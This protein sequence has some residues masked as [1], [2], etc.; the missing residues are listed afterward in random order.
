MKRFLLG[1]AL[2]VPSAGAAQ[3][4]VTSTPDA[5]AI[6]LADAVRQAQ[7]NAPTT[8]QARGA[9]RT[10][11]AA[12]RSALG[13][14]LPTVN[15]T[16]GASSSV[17]TTLNTFTGNLQRLQDT[18]AWSSNQG[19]TATLPLFTGFQRW[20]AVRSTNADLEAA[21]ANE[22]AARYSVALVVK[23]QYF[24]ALAAREQLSAARAQLEASEQQFRAAVARVSAGAATKS[25]SLRSVITLGNAQ[26]AMLT[27][28]NN[29]LVA[30]AA[31][32]RLVQSKT[33]VTPVAADTADPAPIALDSTALLALAE[34]GPTVRTARAQLAS[35]QASKAG[36]LSSYLPTVSLA[37]ST[38]GSNALQTGPSVTRPVGW[39]QRFS[40]NFTYPIFNGFT[41]EQGVVAASVAEENASAQL[42]D[43]LFAA[44]QNLAQLLG[45]L[46]TAQQQITI[47]HASVAAADEDLRVQTQRYSLG[48]STL[49]D[50]LT[51]Q[52]ALNQARTALIQA[53]F[54]Y[55]NAKA[56]LEQLVGR[57]L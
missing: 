43:A 8:T 18:A 1:L 30:N 29:V 4:M 14:F 13:S 36:S 44:D 17:G 37:L 35:A 38:N 52:S 23:Q 19:L 49:L 12:H 48:A 50:V 28:R 3:V 47:Q 32:T 51:S 54:D 56:Q 53:R 45:L 9:Q 11:G 42:R 33:P 6:S 46:R 16:A 15:F 20:N 39:N 21:D 40:L 25:D 26:L 57:D 24:A 7:Q 34:G 2:A 31:L 27:A 55:R 10:T 22:L 41:R 5:R